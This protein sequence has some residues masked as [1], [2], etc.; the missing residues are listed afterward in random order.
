[1]SKLEII[2]I[3]LR[4]FFGKHEME[5]NRPFLLERRQCKHCSKEVVLVPSGKWVDPYDY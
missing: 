2:K 1:M 3:K 5:S 4:C